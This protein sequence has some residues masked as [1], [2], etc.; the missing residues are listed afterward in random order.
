MEAQNTPFVTDETKLHDSSWEPNM[1]N[2]QDYPQ[3]T[4]GHPTAGNLSSDSIHLFESEWSSKVIWKKQKVIKSHVLD[5]WELNPPHWEL[6]INSGIHQ[7]NN[8]N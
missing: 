8:S 5:I 1:L 4:W 2:A 3:T 7:T 6:W